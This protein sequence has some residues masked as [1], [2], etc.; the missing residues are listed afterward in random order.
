MEIAAGRTKNQH[1]PL[2]LFVA[3]NATMMTDSIDKLLDYHLDTGRY[4]G[5]VVH[6]ERDGRVLKHKVVGCLRGDSDAPMREDAV[7]RIASLTKP[8]VTTAAMMLIEQ[9]RLDIDVPIHRYLPELA[10]LALAG[11]K[12]PQRPPSVRDLMRHT[13][14]FA[15]L[16]E[17]R[18]AATRELAAQVGLDM[19]LA[20]MTR[21]QVLQALASLPLVCEPGSAFRYGFS[22]D[23]LGLV[24]EAVH[25]AKLGDILRD[26]V[27]GPLGMHDTSFDLSGERRDRMAIGMPD[28][29]GFFAFTGKFDEGAAGA[30]VIQSGGGG[31][32]ST[33]SD[34]LRFARMLMGGGQLDGV[35]LLSEQTV[36]AMTADQLDPGV[37]GPTTLTGPGFG[38]GFGF[39]VRQDWGV[40]AFPTMTGEVTW[41]GICGPVMYLHPRERWV[42][43]SFNCNMVTRILARME[44]RR[45]AQALL[46]AA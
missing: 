17:I 21:P 23:V 44:F 30:D 8:L 14:G 1:S 33:L 5:A 7:F 42:A 34:Y 27:L 29:A 43:L 11:G 9:G 41:S 15:Y 10:G 20:T 2:S 22:T 31:L 12:A 39:A 40:S 3:H 13:T 36:A 6:I 28:D 35:R 45:A 38:F 32:S 16:N 26:T 4:P 46:T 24:V 19:R 25:G 37:D 18:D